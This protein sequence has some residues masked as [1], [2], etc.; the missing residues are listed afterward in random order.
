MVIKYCKSKV[1]TAFGL[2]FILM[3]ACHQVYANQ[4]TTP[5]SLSGSTSPGEA[6]DSSVYDFIKGSEPSN[7]IYLGMLTWHFSK[8]SRQDDRWS[9]DLIGATYKNVFIGTLINSFDDRAYVIGLQRNLYTYKSSY[10]QEFNVGY[11]MGLI[12]G[13]DERMSSIA[14]HI[15]VLPI[16]EVYMDYSYHNI[17]AEFSYVGV[18][19]TAKFFV[20]F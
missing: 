17:G 1:L 10:N 6:S 5:N 11:R 12:T 19:F 14:E 2:V 9:N 8:K 13:Y 4:V 3:V 15:P 18:V 20:R 7:A 16:P